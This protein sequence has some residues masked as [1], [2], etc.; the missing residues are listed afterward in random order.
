MVASIPASR[1]VSVTPSV[2][3]AGGTGLDLSGLVLSSSTRVPVGVVQS[4]GGADSVGAFF[5]LGSPEYQLA[6]RYFAGYD[7]SPIKPA[8][9]L[10]AQ[11]NVAAVPAYLR[12]GSLAAMTL[13]QLQAIAPGTLTLTIDGNAVTSGAIDL[14]TAVSFSA[15]AALI[16]TALAASD[17]HVTASTTS[18]SPSLDVTAV[19]SGAVAVGDTVAGAGIPAGTKIIAE[20]TGTGGVGTYTMSNNATATASGVSVNVGGVV[21]A[22]DSTWKAFVVTSGLSGAASS[23]TVA[24][25]DAFATAVKLT[26]AAG[27]VVSPGADIA[28]PAAAMANVIAQTQDFAS[29]MTAF[30]PSAD[31]MVAFAAWNNAEANRYTYVQ[32]D[33][34][35]ALTTTDFSATAWGRIVAAAYA[36]TLPFYD[37]IDGA[38]KAAAIMGIFASIDFTRAKGRV[39]LALRS[40]AGLSA[41]VTNALISDQLLAN[42][43]NYY[44]A[45][46]T[47]A[48]GFVFFYDGAVSGPFKW[49]D[50]LVNQI[51]MTNAFQLTLME[52]LTNVT[53]IPYNDAG[54]AL[55]EQALQGPIDDAVSFG[56]IQP[57]VNL[58]PLQVA[59]VNTAAG[60][61]VAG[62][63]EFR[64]WYLQVGQATP[65]VRAARGS[66]PINFWY[67]DGGSVQ[68]IA[69]NS[70]EVQ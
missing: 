56:A 17:G 59:E 61:D 1:I 60:A 66:P 13:A 26:A 10:F 20:G 45:Y 41:G 24:T 51:W 2:V 43:V 31:D 23:I 54:S 11:Y 7:N 16:T 64:G 67:A 49:A 35:A 55:I 6:L 25:V 28:T 40:Q 53:S 14:S 27:A 3:S 34:D 22:Y 38:N 63:I 69:L 29:F 5:G 62:T 68:R 65:Q 32:W 37:P 39:N 70:A 8:A 50:T 42:G 57:G 21:V 9:M 52:L 19:V 46:A 47:A 30:L 15:A 4:F 36:A 48:Q 18:G 33:S 44:G 12:G 58:S